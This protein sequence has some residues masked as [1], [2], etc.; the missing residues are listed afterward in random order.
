MCQ[1]VE[2]RMDTDGSISPRMHWESIGGDTEPLLLYG[3]AGLYL[4]L[5]KRALK[6]R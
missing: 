3:P 4:K 2:K 1:G 5:A 6:M